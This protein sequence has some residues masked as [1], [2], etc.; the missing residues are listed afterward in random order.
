MPPVLIHSY[1]VYT[2]DGVKYAV[3]CLKSS[4][5][6]LLAHWL[7][8]R[9]I[10]SVAVPSGHASAY[11]LDLPRDGFILFKAAQ[12]VYDSGVRHVKIRQ[13][14]YF[15]RGTARRLIKP[16]VIQRTRYKYQEIRRPNNEPRDYRKNCT[17]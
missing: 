15:I 16:I 7:G 2:R 1:L 3:P 5:A 12:D 11:V 13:A 14:R 8:N 10:E 6:T 17:L 4:E 9:G